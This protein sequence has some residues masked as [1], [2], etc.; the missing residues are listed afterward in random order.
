MHWRSH[1]SLRGKLHPQHPDDL[2]VLIHDGGPR[3]T[4][5][6][7]E[8]V[9]VSITAFDGVLFRGRVLNAP[10]QLQSVRQGQPIAFLTSNGTSHAVMVTEKYLGEKPQWRIHP[11]ANCGFT[12]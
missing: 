3:V 6:K 11:C 2:Q 4:N 7:P 1:P 10:K 9:W 8:L 5:R 12:E